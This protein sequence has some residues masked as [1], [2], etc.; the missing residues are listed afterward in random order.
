M[1]VQPLAIRDIAFSVGKFISTEGC[2]SFPAVC[3]TFLNVAT[4]FGF[5]QITSA[6]LKGKHLIPFSLTRVKFPQLQ[7]L[8][9]SD[10]DPATPI[11][12]SF[13]KPS[14][15]ELRIGHRVDVDSAVIDKLIGAVQQ[16]HVLRL[17]SCPGD[18][19]LLD[20][21]LMTPERRGRDLRVIEI[22]GAH[23]SSST[24]IGLLLSSQR[25]TRVFLNVPFYIDSLMRRFSELPELQELSLHH[26]G[27]NFTPASR[28]FLARCTHLR[29]FSVDGETTSEQLIAT[30]LANRN[31]L[32]HLSLRNFSGAINSELLNTIGSLP[33]LQYLQLPRLNVPLN[34]AA[35]RQCS[36]LKHMAIQWVNLGTDAEMAAFVQSL[37]PVTTLSIGYSN[38][39]ITIIPALGQFM[40]QLEALCIIS[41]SECF[42]P[43]ITNLT[44]LKRLVIAHALVG[45]TRSETLQFVRH[46]PKLTA[47]VPMGLSDF[48]VLPEIHRLIQSG[49]SSLQHLEV[50]NLGHEDGPIKPNQP[51]EEWRTV[52]LPD[53]KLNLFY[54]TYRDF[55]EISGGVLTPFT[56]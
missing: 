36:K 2:A 50:R 23:G 35:L 21:L 40:K 37:P 4:T 53:L 52:H 34:L 55:Y 43:E 14:V 48:S 1:A 41:Y 30:L 33:E 54:D 28:E 44:N 24:V 11:P 7:A 16:L 19:I 9:I 15:N 13:N 49:Q 47:F 39:G 31:S 18:R 20:D 27:G 32:T 56:F 12:P 26:A 5:P 29:K 6:Q 17:L 38:M 25:I 8:A 42:A 46:C 45:L 22:T 3:K 51:L 10:M